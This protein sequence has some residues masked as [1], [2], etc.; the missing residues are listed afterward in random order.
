MKRA[1][2]RFSDIERYTNRWRCRI[3]PWQNINSPPDACQK[4]L[5]KEA[6]AEKQS[7]TN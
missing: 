1:F 5:K 6:C 2:A 3:V 7:S 4:K